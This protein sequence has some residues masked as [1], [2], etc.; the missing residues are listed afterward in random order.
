[1]GKF[2]FLTLSNKKKYAN[3]KK[4]DIKLKPDKNRIQSTKTIYHY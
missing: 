2:A 1:M 3:D 4:Q